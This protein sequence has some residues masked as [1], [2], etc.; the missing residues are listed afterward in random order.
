MDRDKEEALEAL[1][2]AIDE[3]FESGNVEDFDPEAFLQELKN[4]HKK[5]NS[6]G[7]A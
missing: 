1:R 4:Q 2:R 5:K 6:L 7:E 3:G